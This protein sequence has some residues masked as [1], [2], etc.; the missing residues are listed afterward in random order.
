MRNVIFCSLLS[1]SAPALACPEL[2]IS[3][4]F[5]IEESK[6]FSFQGPSGYEAKIMEVPN[7]MIRVS[8]FP[9]GATPMDVAMGRVS[10]P[11]V[12][13]NL[14]LRPVP[15][16]DLEVAL[17]ISADKPSVDLPGGG[18]A[19]RDD[20]TERDVRHYAYPDIGGNH[21]ELDVQIQTSPECRAGYADAARQIVRSFQF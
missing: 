20:M 14:A 11:P 7:V 10:E 1:L 12:L 15:A 3:K 17:R 13:V 8:L 5:T 6:T 4:T 18:K 16:S 9:E 19:F 2:D 21:H